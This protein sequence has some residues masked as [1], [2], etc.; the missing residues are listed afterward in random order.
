MSE[1]TTTD[2]QQAEKEERFRYVDLNHPLMQV[3]FNLELKTA[4]QQ[5]SDV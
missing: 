1:P 3:L 4:Q 5:E 2:A